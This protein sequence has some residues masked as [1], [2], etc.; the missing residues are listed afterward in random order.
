V[1]QSW[2]TSQVNRERVRRIAVLAGL[3]VVVNVVARLVARFALPAGTD[4]FI[5]GAWSLLAMVLA[6]AVAAFLWTR[7]RRVPAV[8]GD[9]FFVILATSLLVTLVGPFVSGDPAFGVGSV[10]ELFALCSGL[11]VVGSAAGLLTAVALGLDPTSRAWRA[12]AERVRVAPT[13]RKAARPARSTSVSRRRRQSG[14][15]R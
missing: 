9:L 2:W 4:P 11:L 15:R 7:R 6:V 10:I 3:L 8:V 13:G 12:Q 5:V 14:A 1:V